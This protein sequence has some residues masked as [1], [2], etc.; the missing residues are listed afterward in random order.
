MIRFQAPQ[1]PP[2][3]DIAAYFARA[4]DIRWYSNR[5]PCHELLV[6]R[7]EEFLGAGRC[8]PVV[9]ATLG[10]MLALR[11]LVGL[12]HARRREVLMPS[13]T[14]A[15]T[16]SAVRW[17][18]LEPVF[19]DVEERSWHLDPTRLEHALAARARSAAAVLACSTFGV[20]PPAALRAA[21][22]NAARAAGVP[23]L[24]DSAAG[25]GAT[26]EDE[27]VL[28]H[29]GDAEVFSFHATKPF[30]IGEGGLV[31]TT[32]DDLARRI[33]RLANFGV[34][35]GLVETDVGLNAKL[36]EWSAAT[37]LAVLDGYGEVL[38]CRRERARQI[39]DGIER[40]GYQRQSGTEGAAWQFVP[41][42]APSAD[43]R[44][45]ALDVARS[46]DVEVRSY[47]SVPL[48]RMSAFAS[49]PCADEL[50]CTDDLAERALSL[51]MAN[52]LSISAVEAIV[53]SLVAATQSGPLPRRS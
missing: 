4:E 30:A 26:D 2:V 28:G 25:F 32:N 5:G 51:P 13:F 27:R 8:V 16:I 43:V 20:P 9:N 18:G 1:L 37:A 49:V 38:S 41:V 35:G 50:R 21:W 48:H 39:L 17:A 7:L 6:A 42:L 44:T 31:T 12:G 11:A 34:Q 45:A 24:V 40:Y 19:V 23:L 14:F 3:E 29:Q 36:P 10:L 47:F 46:N 52:D 15:A 22:E 53:G 33:A